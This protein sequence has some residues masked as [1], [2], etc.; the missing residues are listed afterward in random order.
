MKKFFA[1]IYLFILL[2]GVVPA[3]G[4][5]GVNSFF[6]KEDV[7]YL[8]S[9]RNISVEYEQKGDY[10]A[11]YAAGVEYRTLRERIKKRRLSALMDK[12]L[13]DSKNDELEIAN[14]KLMKQNAQM[15]LDKLE[16]NYKMARLRSAQDSVTLE[17]DRLL[18]DDWE[19]TS[20]L[21]RKQSINMEEER[22]RLIEQKKNRIRL[23]TGL[24]FLACVIIVLCVIYIRQQFIDNKELKREKRLAEK[25]LAKAREAERAQDDFMYNMS[26]ELR[27]PM[28]RI[29]KAADEI[30]RMDGTVSADVKREDM[31]IIS[32]STDKLIKAVNEMLERRSKPS[33]GKTLVTLF[34]ILLFSNH[35]PLGAQNNRYGIRDDVY[36]YYKLCDISV[37]EPNIIA[38]TDTLIAMGRK[39]GEKRT[40]CLALDIR[41]G[42]AFFQNDINI[43]RAA[44]KELV[45]YTITTKYTD[46]IFF[47][48]N[49]ILI[50][51]LNRLD[52]SNALREIQAYQQEAIRLNNEYGIAKG[53]F[54]MGEMFRKRGMDK[55]AVEQYMKSADMAD[56]QDGDTSEKAASY[57]RVGE[58]FLDDGNYNDA[59]VYLK[60]AIG[61]VDRDYEKVNPTLQI[62]RLYV[63]KRDLPSATAVKK[64]LERLYV[65]RRII[66]VRLQAYMS[67]LTQYY[68]LLGDNDKAKAYLDSISPYDNETRCKVYV[69]LGDYVN[70]LK[71]LRK[72]ILLSEENEATLDVA[73]LSAF[74]TDYDDR[75]TEIA[76]NNLALRNT[77]L[78]VEQLRRKQ[79]LADAQAQQDS[80]NHNNNILQQKTQVVSD[81][82]LAVDREYEVEQLKRKDIAIQSKRI[83]LRV[84]S[85]TLGGLTLFLIFFAINRRRHAIHLRREKDETL[86]ACAAEEEALRKKE[87][88]LQQVSHEVRTPLNSIVGF[89]ELLS[90]ETVCSML[91]VEEIEEYRMSSRA[92]VNALKM[93]VEGTLELCDAEAGKSEVNKSEVDI[94]ALCAALVEKYRTELK[95]GVTISCDGEVVD[96]VITDAAKIERVLSLLIDNACKFTSQGSVTLSRRRDGEILE[97]AVTDTGCGVPVDKAEDIFKHFY[98]VDSFI[99]GIGL[100]L[101]LCRALTKLLG[102]D[103]KL[104]TVY[105]GG[106]RFIVRILAW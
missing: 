47:G 102:G 41:V 98:K 20:E 60:R 80:I 53:Y 85:F 27:M 22:M 93:F 87:K 46:H 17:N 56:A 39:Y 21:R 16:D 35:A 81:S 2:L 90:D 13:S 28:E 11:A 73:R 55:E 68:L 34:F 82:I 76:N 78:Q 59:E 99:P 1:L 45:D 42:H 49:R 51:Y 44:Q 6:T 105:S 9:I 48:W 36:E 19:N 100:G 92:G 89:N 26:E 7:A 57:C 62:F 69:A 86:A 23:M 50:W 75:M 8:D 25:A 33:V 65:T 24:I 83:M 77:L 74:W 79:E 29:V 15:E 88:F 32:E 18:H 43:L 67:A 38:M 95:E 52:F 37:K 10:M 84:A 72:S 4:D 91:S 61:A 12:Y 101:C 3:W 96:T 97:L 58:I 104:D 103:V 40:I 106:C 31:Y 54:Y 30:G 94:N 5:E 14:I 64:D 71:Y 70:A 63:L 66:G